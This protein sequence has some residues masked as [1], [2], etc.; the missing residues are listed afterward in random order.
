M[1]V[2]RFVFKLT[3]QL[4][5]SEDA[6]FRDYRRS[7]TGDTTLIGTP[8]WNRAFLLRGCSSC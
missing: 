4:G 1:K 3:V 5:R 2:R 8:A 7:G 6:Y